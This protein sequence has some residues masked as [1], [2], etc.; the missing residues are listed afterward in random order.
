MTSSEDYTQKC[1]SCL[2]QRAQSSTSIC[3]TLLCLLTWLHYVLVL[4]FENLQDL[5]ISIRPNMHT[6][7]YC[8]PLS[9]SKHDASASDILSCLRVF[10]TVFQK[11]DL[12]P[13]QW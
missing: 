8:K 12:V 11:P 3:Q 2:S 10:Q 6:I 1:K 5:N 4:F 9:F 13:T 7:P